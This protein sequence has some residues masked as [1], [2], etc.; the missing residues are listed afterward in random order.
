MT[1]FFKIY[2]FIWL[3]WVFVATGFLELQKAEGLFIHGLLAE[4]ASLA[5]KRCLQALQQ[6]Q[7]MGSGAQ[8]QESWCSGLVALQ[9]MGSSGPGI[10]PVSFALA[11]R[12]L[13]TRPPD[14]GSPRR[15]T[16]TQTEEAFLKWVPWFIHS[17]RTIWWNTSSIICTHDELGRK[18]QKMGRSSEELL[19][20]PT[21]LLTSLVLS[22]HTT[23]WPVWPKLRTPLN[24]NHSRVSSRGSNFLL[25]WQWLGL[26]F[27]K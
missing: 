16:Y 14:H 6:R 24:R 25:R 18:M 12:F 1:F 8:A 26:D 11:G 21:G 13:T 22:A 7:H 23:A 3:H 9:N 20:L 5:V 2:L 27:Y 10:K 19:S 17:E 4:A 15:W